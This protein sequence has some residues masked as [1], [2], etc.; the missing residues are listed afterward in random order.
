MTAF[1]YNG[2]LNEGTIMEPK[3]AELINGTVPKNGDKM[4]CGSCGCSI[5]YPDSE[6]QEVILQ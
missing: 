4:F 1:Y 3:R 5:H 6:L 2:T